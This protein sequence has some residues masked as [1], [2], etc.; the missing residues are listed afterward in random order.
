[1]LPAVV[2]RFGSLDCQ[3]DAAI[4]ADKPKGKIARPSGNALNGVVRA[5]YDDRQAPLVR[6]QEERQ[7]GRRP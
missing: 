7:S 1:M 4:L 3:W 6:L 5:G 2:E